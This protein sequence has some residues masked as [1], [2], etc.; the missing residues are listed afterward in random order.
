GKSAV[1]QRN[2]ASFMKTRDAV[3]KLPAYGTLTNAA[4]L[5]LD[6]ILRNTLGRGSQQTTTARAAFG[7]NSTASRST[8]ALVKSGLIQSTLVTG[9]LSEFSVVPLLRSIQ[10]GD[11]KVTN[12]NKAKRSEE[13]RVGKECRS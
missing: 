6:D 11:C 7:P 10:G 3:R 4:R 12:S 8:K 2:A 9:D 1:Y 13:R 5:Q